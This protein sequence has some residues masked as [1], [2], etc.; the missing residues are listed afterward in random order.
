MCKEVCVNSVGLTVSNL[1][2]FSNFALV[3]FGLFRLFLCLYFTFWIAHTRTWNNY[4]DRE[5]LVHI[6]HI[7]TKSHTPVTHEITTDPM[8]LQNRNWIDVLFLSTRNKRMN[9]QTL[10]LSLTHAHTLLLYFLFRLS[11]S[12]TF[13]HF[14]NERKNFQEKN[15]LT[16][17]RVRSRIFVF[18][19]TSQLYFLQSCAH[20][21]IHFVPF[22]L[23]QFFNIFLLLFCT[24][25]V[26]VNV[27]VRLLLFDK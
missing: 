26:W 5:S 11:M 14:L 16:T 25:S 1:F 20:K 15:V 23:L 21:S 22:F 4:S 9:S 19:S 6:F 17:F 24:L 7:C 10:S 18:L 2:L 13:S 8:P 12:R 3:W 27:C